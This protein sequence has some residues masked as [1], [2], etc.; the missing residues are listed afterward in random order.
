MAAQS[1]SARRARAAACKAKHGLVY[2]LAYLLL[3]IC[4]ETCSAAIPDKCPPP[5]D[6]QS[7]KV[8]ESFDDKKMEG[9]WYE[10]AMRDK[11][12]PRFLQ[13]PDIREGCY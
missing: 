3:G 2:S 10:L 11:T 5:S 7:K 9:F 13:V 6:I 8:K 12:Q 1:L 4:M